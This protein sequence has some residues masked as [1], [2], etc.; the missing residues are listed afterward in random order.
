MKT[1]LAPLSRQVYARIGGGLYLIII[2]AGVFAE[3]FV[4][5]RLVRGVH[6]PRRQENTA[7]V[8]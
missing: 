4:R 1:P 5:D 7:S 2:A 8:E 6:V 3:V